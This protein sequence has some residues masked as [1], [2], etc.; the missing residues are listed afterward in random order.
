MKELSI[1]VDESGDFGPY[2][3]HSPY[4]IITMVFHEQGNSIEDALKKL[5]FSLQNIGLANHCVHVGPV[6]RKEDVYSNF[7]IKERWSVLNKIVSFI[8]NI[9]VS[10]K[11]FVIEKKQ[12]ADEIDAVGKLSKQI[13]AFIR[14]NYAYFSQFESM[15]IYY[16][17]G[18]M[19]VTKILSSVFNA[20]FS[21]VVFKKVVPADYRLFQVADLFCSFKLISLKLELSQLSSS[22]K[23]FFKSVQDLK[24]NYLKPLRRKEFK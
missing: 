14:E 19:Q 20:F 24:R 2:R 23:I 16:D 7:L 9:D 5:D 18:Q 8:R 3:A 1:F 11:C 15:K 21:S 10:Y 12:V 4:Y 22:E 17:N 13:S 6:I